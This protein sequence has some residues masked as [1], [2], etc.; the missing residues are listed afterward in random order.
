FVRPDLSRH[1]QAIEACGAELVEAHLAADHF[2]RATFRDPNDLRMTLLES[3]TFAPH[4]PEPSLVSVCGAFLEL[5][6]TT[7]SL[8]ESTAF[9]RAL[10]LSVV[11]ESDAPHASRRLEGHGLVLGLHETGGFRAALTFAA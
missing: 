3:R 7:H 10:G 2:H 5:S 1:V 6:V 9:W 11:A 8:E 4:A